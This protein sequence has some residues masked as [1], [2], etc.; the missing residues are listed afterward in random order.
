MKLR[1][2]QLSR[3]RRVTLCAA[4]LALLISGAA[5]A[6]IHH[7]DESGQAGDAWVKLKQPLIAIHGFS[8]MAFVLLLGTLLAVHIH[9]AWQARRTGRTEPFFSPRLAC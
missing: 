3:L 8:A 9:R 4:S 6:W 7:L 1:G 2:M 5:W